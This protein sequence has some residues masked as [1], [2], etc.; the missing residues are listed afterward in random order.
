MYNENGSTKTDLNQTVNRPI[1]PP[2]TKLRLYE[3]GIY[4]T[5]EH[6][7]RT[8]WPGGDPISRDSETLILFLNRQPN[9]IY[10]P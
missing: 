3:H 2:Q 1:R 5:E 7:M 9:P 8:I 10:N 4:L 6:D